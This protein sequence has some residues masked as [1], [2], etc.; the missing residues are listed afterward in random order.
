MM[1]FRKRLA[2]GHM[3]AVVCVLA[4]AASAAGWGL[5]RMVRGELDTALLSLAQ[6]EL[7]LLPMDASEPIL[8]HEVPTEREPSFTRLDR[9][10]QI[11]DADG[12]PLARSA[13][14]GKA[15]LPASPSLLA[16]LAQG[17]TVFETLDAF[18]DE[19]V[20]VVV[21]PVRG[22]ANVRAIQV[23]GSLDDVNRVVRSATLLLV[24]M[25]IALVVAVG[26]AGTLLTQRAFQAIDDVVDHARRIG[27]SNFAERLPHPGT[28]DEIGK[29]VDTL[30]AMLERLERG[31][32]SQRRF[33]ADAS[34]ELRSPL[35]RLRT[36]MEVALRRP[37]DRTEY[38]E[39]LQSCLEEVDRL[40]Q[41]VEELLTLA[42][43]DAGQ[44]REPVERVALDRIIQDVARRFEPQARERH[45]RIR[46]R[47]DSPV[48]AEIGRGPASLVLANLID[49]AV[50]FSPV[51]G[52]VTV[53]LSDEPGE[54]LVSVTDE[55]PGIGA[56]DL[57]HVFERFY[58]G[59]AAR[60]GH[61]PGVGLGL[62]LTQEIVRAHGGRIE[63]F[64]GPGQGA[65]F[66]LR[67]PRIPN[68]ES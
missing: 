15:S 7:A 46:T 18:G 25:G 48:I 50:K 10:V 61:A 8:I 38:V 40:T 44:A 42:R 58:R 55:G 32:E 21:L 47:I 9:L 23:A 43:L 22:H 68:E 53:S 27:E 17:H 29:L 54:V 35:S 11:I 52:A 36:E 13:N 62:A 56:E 2:I 5:A 59:Q 16:E 30:N 66:A 19:P 4:V 39:T 14:L 24:G 31:F 65:T 64:S 57:P 26:L 49:N 34:H 60:A 51:G 28:R 67:L 20:R 33:T 41:L 12:R 37:R 1:S 3:I 45:I 63:A 6:T